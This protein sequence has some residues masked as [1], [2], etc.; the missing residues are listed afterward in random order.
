[1]PVVILTTPIWSCTSVRPDLDAV[2]PVGDDRGRVREV[3]PCRL[4]GLFRNAVRQLGVVLV[5]VPEELMK[6]PSESTMPTSTRGDAVS[7]LARPVTTILPSVNVV[8][9]IGCPRLSSK[10]GGRSPG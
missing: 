10:V 9:L 2:R 1:M 7:S 3:R 4:P 6:R 8:P 5:K